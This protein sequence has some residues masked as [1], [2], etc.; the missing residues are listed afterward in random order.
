MGGTSI[1]GSFAARLL[2]LLC[3]LGHLNPVVADEVDW[4]KFVNLFI[5]T[6]GPE[7]GTA[8]RSGNV[9]PGAA[10][11]FGVVKAGIE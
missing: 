10:M 11:P 6:E 7:P 2:L 5:G 8:F 4:T 3:M 9:F 1:T